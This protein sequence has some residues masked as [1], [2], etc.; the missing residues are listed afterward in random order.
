MTPSTT[1]LPPVSSSPEAPEV[2]SLPEVLDRVATRVHHRLA[3]E[4]SASYRTGDGA[5]AASVTWPWPL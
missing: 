4:Q 1:V 5:H 2:A 3:T